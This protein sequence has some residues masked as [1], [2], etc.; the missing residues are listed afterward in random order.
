MVNVVSNLPSASG[1]DIP[2][3]A[4]ALASAEV[5]KRKADANLQQARAADAISGIAKLRASVAQFNS[6]MTGL[7]SQTSLGWSASS[8]LTAAIGASFAP[9]SMPREL[10]SEITVQSVAK[11][12]VSSSASQTANAAFGSGRLILRFGSVAN[13][14]SFTAHANGAAVEVNIDGTSNTLNGIARAI[15]RADGRFKTSVLNTADGQ[16]LVIRGPSGETSGFELSA[17]DTD[18][19]QPTALQDLVA[20]FSRSQRAID[21]VV[22]VDGVTV[23]SKSNKLSAVL[24]GMNVDIANASTGDK[25][26]VQA[27]PDTTMLKNAVTLLTQGI[28]QLHSDIAALTQP[29]TATQGAGMLASEASARQLANSLRSLTT[30]QIMTPDGETLTLADL[31]VKTQRDGSL[32]VDT[33]VLD[34]LLERAPALVAGAFHSGFGGLLDGVSPIVSGKA[35]PGLY[36]LSNVSPAT[37]ATLTGSSGLATTIA[38]AAGANEFRINVD[39]VQSGVLSVAAGSYTASEF[40]NAFATVIS[41]DVAL[42]AAGARVD[43]TLGAGG[44]LLL[45]S[46][47]T[48]TASSLAIMEGQDIANHAGLTLATQAIGTAPSALVN[49]IAATATGY[50]SVLRNGDGLLFRVTDNPASSTTLIVTSGLFDRVG[51]LLSTTTGAT[52]PIAARHAF[53]KKREAEAKT[54]LLSIEEQYLTL[55]QRYLTSFARMDSI[56]RGLKSTGSFL[57]N[58]LSTSRDTNG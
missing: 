13:D 11:E 29:A 27:T 17:V 43:A 30:T 14:G 25:A 18:S 22:T 6:S 20:G 33:T 24:T 38:V 54:T 12:Q 19:N 15:T 58:L 49:A 31:G 26:V 10:K 2:K 9:S 44:E 53:W 21:A 51:Q 32:A 34:K 57:T 48:G 45:T 23:V 41:N 40:A 28:N 3:V 7:L 1:F 55:N 37:A 8:S 42:S 39:G 36:T 52:S 16:Q 4:D 46:R 47:K 50:G 35:R 5:A 56:V